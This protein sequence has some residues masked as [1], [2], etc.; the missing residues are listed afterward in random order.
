MNGITML[1]HGLEK[2]RRGEVSPDDAEF[3]LGFFAKDRDILD[4]EERLG[5]IP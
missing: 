1:W 2:V 4:V 3:E 5:V